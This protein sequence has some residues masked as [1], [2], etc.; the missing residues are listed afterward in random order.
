MIK[1]HHRQSFV[2]IIITAFLSLQ[3]SSAH[4]HLAAQHEHGDGQHQHTATAH[5]HQIS[6]HHDVIDS[7][8]NERT[9]ELVS[10]ETHTVVELEQFCTLIKVKHVDQ[11]PALLTLIDIGFERYKKYEHPFNVVTSASYNSYLDITSIRL[12]APPFYS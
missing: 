9:S 8:Y 10:H 11:L 5:N 2:F 6:T 4:V 3:F 7:A 12:R 1:R